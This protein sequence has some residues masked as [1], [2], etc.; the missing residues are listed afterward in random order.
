MNKKAQ[1]VYFLFAAVLL[2]ALLLTLFFVGQSTSL[3]RHSE[4]VTQEIITD[5]RLKPLAVFIDSCAY[6]SFVSSVRDVASKGGYVKLEGTKYSVDPED[7]QIYTSPIFGEMPIRYGFSLERGD[8]FVHYLSVDNL[9]SKILSEMSDKFITCLHDFKSFPGLKVEPQSKPVF[10]LR[11]R[12]KSTYVVLHYPLKILFPNGAE[13]MSTFVT[14]GNLDL[15]DFVK[16]INQFLSYLAASHKLSKN[17]D[18]YFEH[19]IGVND[20]F[21]PNLGISHHFKIYNKNELAQKFNDLMIAL[22]AQTRVVGTQRFNTIFDAESLYELTPYVNLVPYDV[23]V[24]YLDDAPFFKVYPNPD[25]PLIIP[26]MSTPSLFFS[27]PTFKYSVGYV[28]GVPATVV[29]KDHNAFQGSG[30][31]FKFVVLPMYCI[32]GPCTSNTNLTFTHVK[33]TEDF[34]T[35]YCEFS[36]KTFQ[37][38]LEV[39]TSDLSQHIKPT[40]IYHCGQVSCPEFPKK[41][42]N[43]YDFKLPMC[44]NASIEV[45]AQNYSSKEVYFNSL[46]GESKNM[47]ITLPKVYIINSNTF[48]VRL[49][50]KNKVGNFIGTIGTRFNR[51]RDQNSEPIPP[52]TKY[53]IFGKRI[54]DNSRDSF[55][56]IFVISN[57]ETQNIPFHLSAGTYSVKT[58]VVFNKTSVIPG[59]CENGIM[60]NGNCVGIG[61]QWINKTK[62]NETI[63]GIAEYNFTLTDYELKYWHGIKFYLYYDDLPKDMCHISDWKIKMNETLARAYL[64]R[65]I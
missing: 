3:K 14:N 12:N 47:V 10:D 6:Q 45:L 44:L 35:S 25:M 4:S 21:P 50:N 40:F 65:I 16:V 59:C 36:P 2:A 34:Q 61:A 63:G 11:L 9:K 38:S 8:L 13:R 37:L 46:P 48:S 60:I 52:K 15:N 51:L 17:I 27:T 29:F 43:K 19:F 42:G 56:S 22:F 30:L 31:D 18:E 1:V 54:G 39:K 7:P 20:I 5:Q 23:S 28:M 33:E 58:F 62:M 53:V 49:L 57:D 26:K 32:D 64:P 41:N 24:Y 55:P